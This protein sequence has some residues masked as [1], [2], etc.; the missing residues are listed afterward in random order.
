MDDLD[1][2]RILPEEEENALLSD[3]YDTATTPSGNRFTVQAEVHAPPF[4]A[5]PAA[6]TR[7]KGRPKKTIDVTTVPK[8]PPARRNKKTTFIENIYIRPNVDS[9]HHK[10]DERSAA[11]AAQ[12][13]NTPSAAPRFTEQQFNTKVAETSALQAQRYYEQLRIEMLEMMQQT[14]T[15]FAN[16]SASLPTHTP[17][18]A[19]VSSPVESTRRI[20]LGIPNKL[21][22]SSLPE[23]KPH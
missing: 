6:N 12:F 15:E 22:L 8:R 1:L 9:L 4:T 10:G 19:E 21:S 14:F 23:P 20:T 11:D 17:S 5:P 7:N 2:N 13:L 16:G 18:A 3:G